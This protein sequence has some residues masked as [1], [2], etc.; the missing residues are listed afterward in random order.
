MVLLPR[1]MNIGRPLSSFRYLKHNSMYLYVDGWMAPLLT[2][3]L[4]KEL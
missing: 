4:S 1:G 2:C 3:D